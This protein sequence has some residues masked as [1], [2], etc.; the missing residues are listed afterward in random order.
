[1]AKKTIICGKR[2]GV[3]V[4]VNVNVNL[5]SRDQVLKELTSKSDLNS[6]LCCEVMS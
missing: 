4:N 3:V 2:S 6:K 5:T 1:M